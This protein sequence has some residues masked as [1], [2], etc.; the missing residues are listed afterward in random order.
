[1]IRIAVTSAEL[2]AAIESKS[3]RW[4]ERA[5]EKKAAALAAGK[6]G[7]GDGIWSEIKEIFILRQE[8][9][10]IYCE[11]PLPKV[12]S[13]S[14]AKVAV[15]YDVEHYRPK[16][17]VTFWPTREVL[18]R[19][20]SVEEYRTSVSSG[21]PG[22][23]VRLAF[24]PFNYIA[25]CKVCNTSYKADRFPIAGQP[26][27]VSEEWATLNANERPLLLFPFGEAGDE[28]VEYL[29]FQ[30]PTVH[31]LP[32]AGHERLR[33]QAVIDF[34]ELDTREGLLEL[35]CV[36]ILFLWGQLEKRTSADPQKKAKAEAFLET[37]RKT[38]RH[39]HT[40]C[41]RAF[42]DLYE[43]NPAMAERWQEAA[44]EYLTSKDPMV[45]K[46]ILAADR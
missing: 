44:S 16:N 46:A 4:I 23:Y 26:D 27:S 25:S 6:V 37:V 34:F 11:F 29:A 3:P 39:P 12:D 15:D 40:A 43:K 31:P 42:I 8:F 18:E 22:G 13:A 33:A 45:L 30:G 38:C 20:P 2:L 28:P 17:R 35:R 9:K 41:G 32:V 7:E 5:Q 1:M 14:A 24:D 10:C 21:D 19:R 36:L